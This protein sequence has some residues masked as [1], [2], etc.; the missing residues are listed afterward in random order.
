MFRR[1]HRP[2]TTTTRESKPSL[3]TRLKGPN[4]RKK[5][6]KTKTTTTRHG[7]AT[8]TRHAPATTTRHGPSTHRTTKRRWGMSQP[9]HHHKRKV[10]MGD[11]VSGAMMKLKGSLTGRPGVKVRSRLIG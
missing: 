4:A 7:P 5:T 2:T 1:H 6:V 9:Q 11:K 3:M 8:T 10:T